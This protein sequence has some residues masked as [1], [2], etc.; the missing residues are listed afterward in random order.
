MVV[1]F[2]PSRPCGLHCQVTVA[3]PGGTLHLQ[4]PAGE[5]R[6]WRVQT[7]SQLDGSRRLNTS[8]G[9]GFSSSLGLLMLADCCPSCLVFRLRLVSLLCASITLLCPLDDA[10]RGQDTVCKLQASAGSDAR[11]QLPSRL[12]LPAPLRA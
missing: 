7:G 5:S 9:Q 2:Y 10:K 8:A 6:A 12:A 1:S 4:R 11:P 3:G